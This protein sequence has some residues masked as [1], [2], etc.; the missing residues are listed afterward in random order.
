MPV[1]NVIRAM[2]RATLIVVAGSALAF[3]TVPALVGPSTETVRAGGLVV[4][5]AGDPAPD[6]CNPLPD[7]CSLREA[8][9]ATTGGETI[10]FNIA[11]DGPHVIQPTSV[12][13]GLTDS[14]SIDGYTQPGSSANSA[15]AWQPGNA[16]LQIV[17]DGSLGASATGLLV[18]GSSVI[19]R[20]LVIQNFPGHGIMIGAFASASIQGNYIG[21]DYTGTVAAPNGGTGINVHGANTSIGGTAAANRNLISG[22][23]SDGIEM[24][25]EDGILIVGN[26][27][28]TDV[29]GTVALPNG[30][31]GIQLRNGPESLIGGA[32]AGAGN[33]IS[34]NA[35][36]GLTMEGTSVNGINARGNR[37]GT[38]GDGTTPLGNLGHGIY[39][40]QGAF[41]N[42]IGGVSPG[43][44]NTI[45]FNGGD[46]VSLAVGAGI[47]NYLDPN[48]THSNAG[49]GA[50]LKDDG[51]TPND[52]DD[53]DT[54]PNNVQN[55]PV[56]TRAE[57]VDGILE[58]DGTLNSI[59]G[60][61]YTIFIF[62]NSECDPSGYGEG[63]RFLGEDIAEG[64][65]P[66]YTFEATIELPV[67]NGEYITT[68][69]SDPVSTS[70]FSECVAIVGAPSPTPSPTPSL[71]PTPSP[72]PSPTP[73]PTPT[74]TPSPTPSPTPQG[75]ARTW[76]DL[77][78]TNGV[79]PIDSLK[80]LRTDAGLGSIRPAGCPV[81]GEEVQIGGI[82]RIWGDVDCSLALGPVDSLKILRHDAGLP[83]DQAVDCP[84][85]SSQV[86]VVA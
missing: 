23:A 13:P 29:T 78:C 79:N 35:G 19:V 77:D 40:A 1:R 62:A 10:S 22:N 48:I 74:P 39:I 85:M 46:G 84:E 38:A 24:A 9:L 81:I 50:D 68:S 69:A 54:G 27:I 59:P 18:G 42:T 65:G 86:F 20:G 45:A 28:G 82:T 72:T 43:N 7:G 80:A 76:G 30:G 64:I 73:T 52:Q 31:D 6:G 60:K 25:G 5:L 4:T 63:E 17:L 11:G 3:L 44:W 67:Y 34:A 75:T 36:N 47:N 33:L 61:F 71:T 56:V 49:L 41:D 58:I 26:F 66:D 21:T 14:V 37:I 57:V 2:V 16:S 15:A 32:V 55:F 12:L 83:V 53:L 51:V 8:L 70:E